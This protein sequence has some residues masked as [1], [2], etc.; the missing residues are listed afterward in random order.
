M[1]D[2]KKIEAERERIPER[3]FRQ[4]YGGEFIEGSGSVFRY[5]REAATGEFAEPRPDETYYAGLDLAKVEDYSV[6]VIMDGNGRVVFFDR[7]HRLDWSLQI[8]RVK[9]AT[10]RFNH[11]R[12]FVDTT[13]AG[14]PVFEALR[15]EELNVE[16]YPFTAKSKA[17]LIDNL[18]LRLER[19]E[20]TLPQTNLC[21][22]LIDEL[23]A[24]E[25]SVSDAGNVRTGA[26]GGMHDDCVIALALAA[27]KA[28]QGQFWIEVW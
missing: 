17:A 19:R 24:F 4:E 26:P 13:G 7:F 23:E 2:R 12:T 8:A 3:V 18:A 16:A 5:V 25:F 15:K 11:A 20:L 14:E 9:A 1:L 10:E 21:P 28:R 22:V 6:L 27:W